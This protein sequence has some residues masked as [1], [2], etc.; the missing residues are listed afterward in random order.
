M[1]KEW[2]Y[3][4][5]TLDELKTLSIPTF[6]KLVDARARRTLLRTSPDQHK[7]LLKNITAGQQAV[8]THCRDI[9]ILPQLV[10]KTIHV[11]NGKEFVPVPIDADMLGHRLG[12]FALTRKK[13]SHSAPGIG[14]T[15]S[16]ASLSVR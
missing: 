16:S 1:V 13:V 14:A 7:I 12:E 11:H 10:G 8:H 5:K 9:V 4:G 2:R 6:A 15:R 3:R